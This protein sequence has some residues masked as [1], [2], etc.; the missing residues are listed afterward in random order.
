M[1]RK[2]NINVTNAPWPQTL[3]KINV[4]KWALKV[5]SDSPVSRRMNGSS[6]HARGPAAEDRSPKVLF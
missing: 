3:W 1:Q 2:E 5:V 4:F 6:F